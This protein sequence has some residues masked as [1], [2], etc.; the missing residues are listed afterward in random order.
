QGAVFAAKDLDL[1]AA[2]GAGRGDDVG[3]TVAVHIPG[4]D[5]DAAPERRI[6]SEEAEQ[7]LA[8]DAVEDLDVRP[9]ALV[10]GGDDVRMAVAVDVAGGHEDAAAEVLVEGEEAAQRPGHELPGGAAEDS[11][12]PA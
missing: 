1:R 7:R 6:V 9:A 10:G 3:E 11:H 8:G 5:A 2:A 12:Q 4:R